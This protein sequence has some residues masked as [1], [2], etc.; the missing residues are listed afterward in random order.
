MNSIVKIKENYEFRRAY[1]KGEALVSPYFVVYAMRNR[2][3]NIRLGITVSKKIGG[4]VARNRAKRLITAAFRGCLPE[5]SE[6]YDFIIVARNRILSV[7]STVVEEQLK[8]LF[9]TNGII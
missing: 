4:A 3:G 1:K 6:G 5:I 9:K 8:K 2:R 7:K